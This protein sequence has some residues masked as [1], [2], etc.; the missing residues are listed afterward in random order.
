VTIRE[1]QVGSSVSNCDY[2]VKEQI[3]E[4]QPQI[5]VDFGAGGGKNCKLVREI[6]GTSSYIMAVEGNKIAA[7][8][9]C[10]S[11][12]YDLVYNEL[13]EDWVEKNNKE[14][15][16]AIFGDVLE[17]LN[18]RVI[19]RV[20]Q[21]TLRHFKYIIIV[22]PLY[23]IFQDD[24]YGN[25]LEIHRTYITETYFDCYSPKEKHIIIGSGYTIMNLLLSGNSREMQTIWKK[26]AKRIL[27]YTILTLQPLG[28]ARLFVD[29]LKKYFI[30]YKS[31]VR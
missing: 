5:V 19:R 27:H 7:D 4:I 6:M 14:V 18:H 8:I 15:D 10:D 12:F 29:L 20:L 3:R 21:K 24:S 9:L 31:I 26:L 2:V 23:D 13:I 16:L 28:L 22:V 30:K 17:H 1:N 11:D 25:P